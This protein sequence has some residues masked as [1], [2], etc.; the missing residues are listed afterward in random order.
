MVQLIVGVNVR[1]KD[2]R[3]V[4]PTSCTRT[5]SDS[6]KGTRKSTS[7][8]ELNEISSELNANN[9][10]IKQGNISTLSCGHG[11][12]FICSKSRRMKRLDN[13]QPNNYS[14]FIL[15]CRSVRGDSIL[16]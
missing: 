4:F 2:F 3:N 16:C 11:H 12:W 1:V 10:K 9:L 7:V 5:D 6:N 13:K 14:A 15:C 8:E